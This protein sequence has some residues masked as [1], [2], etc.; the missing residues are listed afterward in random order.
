[1]IEDVRY[2]ILNRNKVIFC[3]VDGPLI[4]DGSFY[5]DPMC[6][7]ERS[8]HNGNAVGWLIATL[9]AANA[10]LVM[11]TTHNIHDIE[12]PLTAE[13][14]TVKDD[15]IRW[16]VSEHWFHPNWKTVYPNHVGKFSEHPR[17]AAVNK[18]LAENG[19]DFEWVAFDDDLF[20]N[21]R[22]F[23]LSFTDGITYSDHLLACER[24]NV[25]PKRLFYE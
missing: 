3:D 16:G 23:A 19:P 1:M 9:Q 25:P 20:H 8:H 22:Q 11:N 18:W 15:L 4:S 24:L 5:V 7:M 6:S 17:S 2:P 14:R 10:W 12:D 21:D 13:K